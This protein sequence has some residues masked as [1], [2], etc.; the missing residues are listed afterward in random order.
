MSEQVLDLV[1]GLSFLL[2]IV[3]SLSLYAYCIIDIH[4][5]KVRYQTK[6]MLWL[7]FIWSMPLIGC[8]IYLLNRKNIWR[9]TNSSV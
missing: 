3:A 6:R 7:N 8:I 1:I 9:E 4:R 5:H 2:A